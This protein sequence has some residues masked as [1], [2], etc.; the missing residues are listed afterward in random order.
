VV[1]LLTAVALPSYRGHLLRGARLDAVEALTRVQVVQEQYRSHHGLYAG[2]LSALLGVTP[3]SA[4]GRY[5]LSLQLTGPE[6]Y[7]ATALAVGMQAQDNACPALTLDVRE[8]FAQSGPDLRCWN[9]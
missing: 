6:A 7:R 3:R 9:R 5:T 2:E 8:G 1:A 4:Q